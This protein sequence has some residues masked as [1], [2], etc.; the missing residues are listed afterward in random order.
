MLG[1]A[2]SPVDLSVALYSERRDLC[3]IDSA[4]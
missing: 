2:V 1:A 3:N 4:H